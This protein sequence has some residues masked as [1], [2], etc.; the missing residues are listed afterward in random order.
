MKTNDIEN[1]R[2]ARIVPNNIVNIYILTTDILVSNYLQKNI[3]LS[4]IC[5]ICNYMPYVRT[6][7][8][9]CFKKSYERCSRNEKKMLFWETVCPLR[10]TKSQI[11]PL[12]I[13]KNLEIAWYWQPVRHAITCLTK[14]ALFCSFE[15]IF[16]FKTVYPLRMTKSW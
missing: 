9:Q 3:H 12:S 1:L 8:Y 2:L 13:F 7:T 15:N 4:S 11:Q 10:I 16:I 5:C 6:C 14:K